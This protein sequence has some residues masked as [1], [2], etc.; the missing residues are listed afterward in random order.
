[1]GD[2]AAAVALSGVRLGPHSNLHVVE[3]PLRILGARIVR[4]DDRDVRES[5][6]HGAH[7]GPLAAVAIASRT[8]H[9]NQPAL[10][11]GAQ[12]LECPREGLWRVGI[13]AQY[14][15]RALAAPLRPT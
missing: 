10:G 5:H 14:G 6:G 8:E 13:I 3:D 7:R 4:R 11:E 15:T 2:G 12:R 9:D 1:M